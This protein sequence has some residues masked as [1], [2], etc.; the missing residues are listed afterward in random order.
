MKDISNILPHLKL[1]YMHIKFKG[2]KPFSFVHISQSYP[3]NVLDAQAEK[4]SDEFRMTIS[5]S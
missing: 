3:G 1:P 5:F 4:R 2:Y